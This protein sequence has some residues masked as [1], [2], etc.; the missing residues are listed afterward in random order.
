MKKGS[1]FAVVATMLCVF[2]VFTVI[3]YADIPNVIVIGAESRQNI[4]ADKAAI[5]LQSS[6]TESNWLNYQSGGSI[7]IPKSFAVT[8]YSGN[9]LS[10]GYVYEFYN[11][12]QQMYITT[13]E[14]AVSS[15]ENGSNLLLNNYYQLVRVLP[16]AVYNDFSDTTFTL[17]GYSGNSIY[18][19][20]YALDHGTLYTIEFNY[21]T[22]NRKVCDMYVESI[23]DSFSTI[24]SVASGAIAKRPGPADLDIIYADINYPNYSWM[25]L[26]E[27]KN[28]VVSHNKAVYCFKDPDNDVW[29]EG[30]YFTVNRGTVVFLLKAKDMPA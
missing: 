26:D 28:A 24:G 3:A 18:F 17:S 27:Y 22:A 5:S 23:C 6:L 13:A 7:H 21:P 12:W 16:E 10:E 11:A 1:V 20:R 19:I 8:N 14:Y 30:N 9:S 15:Q 4:T 2:S 25:Y 29:R